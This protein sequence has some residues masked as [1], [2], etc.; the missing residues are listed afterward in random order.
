MMWE[1]KINWMTKTFLFHLIY[2]ILF[3]P[4]EIFFLNMK[5]K[6]KLQRSIQ[7]YIIELNWLRFAIIL[8]LTL[9]STGFAIFQLEYSIFFLIIHFVQFWKG[10][11]HSEFGTFFQCVVIEFDHSENILLCHRWKKKSLTFNEKRSNHSRFFHFFS[12]IR[13]RGKYQI[14]SGAIIDDLHFRLISNHFHIEL[15]SFG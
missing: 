7:E 11:Q 8:Y 9:Y 3:I 12:Y 5:W 10:L 14:T 15:E 4:L 13:P 1:I 2:Y 6:T